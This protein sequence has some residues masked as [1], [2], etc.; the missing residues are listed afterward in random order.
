M[1]L[2]SFIPPVAACIFLTF[3]AFTSLAYSSGEN[4]NIFEASAAK[5]SSKDFKPAPESIET[6]FGT[7]EF[8][9]GGYTE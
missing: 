3:A 8:A 2:R 1:I 7:L 6:N 5:Q 4:L 9:G